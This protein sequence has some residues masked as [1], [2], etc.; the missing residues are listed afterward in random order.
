M[1]KIIKLS[2]TFEY[3]KSRIKAFEDVSFEIKQGEMTAITGRSGSGKT[4]LL[5]IIG[6]VFRQTEG[7]Y[8][9]ES[10]A[11]VDNETARAKFRNENIGF[12]LQ[13]FALINSKDVMYNISLPLIYK[14][15]DKNEVKRRVTEV[16]DSLGIMD[17]LKMY[18]LMLSG[19][20]RQRVAVARAVIANPK[21]ILADEPTAS[22]DN[23]NKNEVI[24][25]LKQLNEKGK[26]ILVVTHDTDVMEACGRVLSL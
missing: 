7:E 15:I 1:I 2:K 18:P 20:E 12:V 5:N 19:G 11:L 24:K 4:T 3:K 23:E 25:L 22:L 26:T 13:D 9:F 21:I 8:L 16:S 17:K 10:E 14:G 6:G